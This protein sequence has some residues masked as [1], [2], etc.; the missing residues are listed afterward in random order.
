MLQV[1][2]VI[3]N[4]GIQWLYVCPR[5]KAGKSSSTQSHIKS[6]PVVI[7]CHTLRIQQI[8]LDKCVCTFPPT[9]S[10][11]LGDPVHSFNHSWQSD[12]SCLSIISQVKHVTTV[13]TRSCLNSVFLFGLFD[14]NFSV[15]HLFSAQAPGVV[16]LEPFDWPLASTRWCWKQ[17]REVFGPC[18][19]DGITQLLWV[20]GLHIHVA[21]LRLLHIL[22]PAAAMRLEWSLCRV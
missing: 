13:L 2:S 6:S 1:T 15:H 11:K 21:E 7:P 8:C 5:L 17:S 10:G 3:W 22:E 9:F 16:Y 20:W 18:S 12:E 19:H 14:W 4:I